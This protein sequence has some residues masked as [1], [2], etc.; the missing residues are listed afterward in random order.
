M[1]LLLEAILAELQKINARAEVQMA[2][3]SQKVGSA[4]ELMKMAMQA[5]SQHGGA[6]GQ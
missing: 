3:A 6:N 4:D 2:E 1:R 5:L